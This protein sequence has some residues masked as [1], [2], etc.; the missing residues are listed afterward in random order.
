[1]VLLNALGGIDPAL[2]IKLIVIL[3]FSN[4]L[5]LFLSWVTCRCRM[6]WIK[7]MKPNSFYEKLFGLHCLFWK[8]FV[9]SVIL[10]LIIVLMVFGIPL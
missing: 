10:H 4:L 5:F 3:G 7:N 2:G 9:L 1:M 8:L 6:K